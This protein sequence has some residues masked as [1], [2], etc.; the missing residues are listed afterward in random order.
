MTAPPSVD[1]GGLHRAQN[2]RQAGR[3]AAILAQIIRSC[4]NML[5][6]TPVVQGSMHMSE[7]MSNPLWF[8]LFARRLKGRCPIHQDIP[9]AAAFVHAAA[10]SSRRRVAVSP[11][12]ESWLHATDLW[13]DASVLLRFVTYEMIFIAAHRAGKACKEFQSASTSR[14]GLRCLNL[15]ETE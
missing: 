12:A 1:T 14:F 7:Q 11:A 13:L 2:S 3:W 4:A 9:R 6:A 8:L 10:Q 15:C 5:H